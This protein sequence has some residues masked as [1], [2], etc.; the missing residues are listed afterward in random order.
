M[1][2]HQRIPKSIQMYS[3]QRIKNV[4][5]P[6]IAQNIKECL[7]VIIHITQ[8]IIEQPHRI[9]QC[10]NVITLQN[11][12]KHSNVN[13]TIEYHR[14]FKCYHN[15]VCHGTLKCNHN[16]EYHYIAFKC[17]LHYRISQSIKIKSHHGIPQSIKML[18]LHK[19]QYPQR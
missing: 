4:I 19:I 5:T 13:N 15:I 1:F 7:N 6:I 17:K 14:A 18:P 3:Q 8:N 2:S 11:T 10:S 16:I 9:S 12:I